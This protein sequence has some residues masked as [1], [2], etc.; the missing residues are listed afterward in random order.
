VAALT[1]AELKSSLSLP[2]FAAPMFLISG[3]D[4]VVEAC[5][6]GIVGSFPASNCRTLE[7]FEA[8]LRD[9]TERLA[10]LRRAPAD[11]A[12]AP[13]A[14]NL[15]LH[16]TNPRFE[17]DL[18]LVLRYQPPIVITA[19]GSPRRVVD[20]VHAYGGL[21]F[22]DVNSVP[23]AR[24]AADCGVDGLALV[25]SGAGG[26]TG[27][28]S[29]FAF[30]PAVRRWWNGAIVLGGAIGDAATIRA[31][32]IL[33]ADFAYVGTRFIPTPES[34]A[35]PA[36]KRMVV[37]GTMD[38]LIVSNAFTGAYAS[39]LKPS[40][41]KAGHDLAALSPRQNYQFKGQLGDDPKPWKGIFSA[42]QGLELI[43]REQSVAEIVAA[44]RADYARLA[45]R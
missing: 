32:E 16:R 36:H 26:H 37:E 44:L 7:T 11:P 17:A 33:G 45:R 15:V 2:V 1:L 24:K 35:D 3:P 12:I 22:A 34:L 30:V 31:T 38:D 18:E 28:L 4:L 20:P 42:G 8:W 39:W 13:W 19:L 10:A 23:L 14:V 21:V 27:S 43:E 9:I 40:I 25:A 29:P 6:A 5:R 41:I